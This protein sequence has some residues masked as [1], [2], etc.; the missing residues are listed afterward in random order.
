MW[1]SSACA[2][3]TSREQA[4]RESR[5]DDGDDNDDND[6][7]DNDNDD[8]D[9]DDNDNDDN[10][11]DDMMASMGDGQTRA[12]V[13]G[14]GGPVGRG[15]EIGLVTGLRSLGVELAEADLVVGT[16]AGAIVGAQLKLGRDLYMLLGPAPAATASS[17]TVATVAPAPSPPDL[18]AQLTEARRRAVTSA[19]PEAEYRSIGQLSVST[20]TIS[21]HEYVSGPRFASF[22][23]CDAWPPGVLITSTDVETGQAQVWTA[24]SG[25]SLQKAIASS[26]ALPGAFPPVT[27]GAGKER[28]MDGGVRSMLHAPLAAGHRRILVV[29]C[30]PIFS[31]ADDDDD[32]PIAAKLIDELDEL[33]SSSDGTHIEVIEPNDEFQASFAHRLLDF[34]LVHDAYQLGL[35]QAKHEAERAA[36]LWN[37]GNTATVTAAQA[38]Q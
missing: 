23:Q 30:F 4:V 14:G 38:L 21:E 37:T 29:S 20:P 2:L 36:R 9:N 17:S 28:Y 32:D 5:Q 19:D 35:R 34:S 24:A 13:L 12:L 8:N 15:W 16:S 3:K 31:H 1:L 18:I 25:V 33:K 10:D 22:A 11:N 26:T 27:V 7:D 6:N